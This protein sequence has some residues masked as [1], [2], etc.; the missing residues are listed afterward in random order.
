MFLEVWQLFLLFNIFLLA[1]WRTSLKF[2]DDGYVDG[3]VEAT[4]TSGDEYVVKVLALLEQ[5]GIIETAKGSDG[6]TLIRP[7]KG[8]GA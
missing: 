2:Y 1:I 5:E 4:N 8:K 7:G 6:E 3:S